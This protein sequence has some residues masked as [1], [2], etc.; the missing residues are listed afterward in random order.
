MD[1]TTKMSHE[2]EKGIRTALPGLVVMVCSIMGAVEMLFG[3]NPSFGLGMEATSFLFGI[4]VL[5]S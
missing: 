1:D 3:S 5:L 2:A 4:A